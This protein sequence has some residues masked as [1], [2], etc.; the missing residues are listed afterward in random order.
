LSDREQVGNVIGLKLLPRLIDIS[1]WCA[2]FFGALTWFWSASG[3]GSNVASTMFEIEARRR[4]HLPLRGSWR[5]VD[6][7][8]AVDKP[9]HRHF[10]IR[11]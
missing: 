5:L 11:S 2:G 7:R 10:E 9:D 8:T 3:P 1:D 4:S 6:Q